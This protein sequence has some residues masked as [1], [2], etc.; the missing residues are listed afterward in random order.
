M[1][2]QQKTKYNLYQKIK[3]WFNITNFSI[4]SII[5][6]TI[7]FGALLYVAFANQD[8]VAEVPLADKYL[9]EALVSLAG[10][11]IAIQTLMI[12]RNAKR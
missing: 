6:F 8:I 3:S 1:K 4:A 12:N 10:I 5:F 7:T 11:H 9:F 2:N